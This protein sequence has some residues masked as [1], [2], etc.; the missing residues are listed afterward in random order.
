MYIHITA[1]RN[2]RYAS[3]FWLG[4]CEVVQLF[5]KLIR[6]YAMWPVAF[7][8]VYVCVRWE[9]P[10]HSG[11]VPLPARDQHTH[12]YTHA[13]RIGFV[14]SPL[15]RRRKELGLG[16]VYEHLLHV[17]DWYRTLIGAALSG[18]S[19]A[20]RE[21]AEREIAEL[22]ATGPIDSIDHWP[23]M[24]ATAG[25]RRRSQPRRHGVAAPTRRRSL[26]GARVLGQQR[27]PEAA[28]PTARPYAR[29]HLRHGTRARALRRGGGRAGDVGRR[30]RD[31]GGRVDLLTSAHT[32]RGGEEAAGASGPW[33]IERGS[34]RVAVLV[35]QNARASRRRACASPAGTPQARSHWTY[36]QSSSR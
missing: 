23:A 7:R 25:G 13:R 12:A 19:P 15:L 34:V 24:A 33:I 5:I 35:W 14:H 32:R 18:D 21:A 2:I 17:S 8:R 11:S 6:R 28:R 26:R 22:L 3:G 31:K 27:G 36:T 20:A 10:S 1:F 4:I 30:E 16:H 29:T 9:A